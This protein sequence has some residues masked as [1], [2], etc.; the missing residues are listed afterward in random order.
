M[1]N[2]NKDRSWHKSSTFSKRIISFY[3][4]QIAAY[5]ALL[6]PVEVDKMVYDCLRDRFVA[7]DKEA[8]KRK[9][10]DNAG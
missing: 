4:Y 9:E 6:W 7:N 3:F 8:T 1:D 10:Q 2:E 5:S